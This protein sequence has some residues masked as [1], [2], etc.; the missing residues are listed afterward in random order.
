MK[1]E[2]IIYNEWGEPDWQKMIPKE[3]KYPNPDWFYR[4]GDEVPET[5]D[6]LSEE[7]MIISLVGLR[8]A[9][10]QRGYLRIDN[11]IIESHPDRCVAS[12]CISWKKTEEDDHTTITDVASATKENTSGIFGPKF[13][14]AIAANRAFCRAVRLSLGINSVSDEEVDPAD[15]NNPPAEEAPKTKSKP[16]N[17]LKSLAEEK[18]FDTFTK[19]RSVFKDLEYYH[20][21]QDDW[22]DFDNL[23]AKEC[24]VLIAK[25]KSK[26]V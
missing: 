26:E 16:Q 9:A 12:C 6:G 23:P 1:K 21:K 15:I 17:A 25:L 2:D 24:R 13:L 10:R 14:E 5:V 3:F 20:K 22:V 18:G 19:L 7:Q 8:W 11:E 4:R